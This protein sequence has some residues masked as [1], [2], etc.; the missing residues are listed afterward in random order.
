MRNLTE[1]RDPVRCLSIPSISCNPS[2]S[3]VK[4]STIQL[5]GLA[6]L[7][8]SSVSLIAFTRLADPPPYPTSFGLEQFHVD[9]GLLV[10]ILMLSSGVAIYIIAR[11][12]GAS[13]SWDLLFLALFVTVMVYSV[14]ASRI[15]WNPLVFEPASETE[16][17]H[18]GTAQYLLM[19]GRISGY[20][21]YLQWPASFIDLTAFWLVLGVVGEQQLVGATLA[22]GAVCNIVIAACIYVFS[23]F[24]M[25]SRV[26][27]LMS[28]IFY[29]ISGFYFVFCRRIPPSVQRLAP[30]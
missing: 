5:I 10:G 15:L 8:I 7:A 26:K 12:R 25:K 24:F 3:S 30:K 2:R 18:L 16:P 22:F 14:T 20:V 9:L 13:D 28:T 23:T 6:M 17:I 27:A 21:D 29:Y 1:E 4:V 19:N 11:L